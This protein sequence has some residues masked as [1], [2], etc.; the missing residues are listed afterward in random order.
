MYKMITIDG[1][2]YITLNGLEVGF[3]GAVEDELV[4][5]VEFINRLNNNEDFK[6]IAKSMDI[7]L[8]A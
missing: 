4:L 3:D 6:V 8:D 2:V 1:I 7:R 5:M